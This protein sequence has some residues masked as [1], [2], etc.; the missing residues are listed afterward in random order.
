MPR[1]GRTMAG[2]VA[3]ALLAGPAA[4]ASWGLE[5]HQGIES[6]GMRNAGGELFSFVCNYGDDAHPGLLGVEFELKGKLTASTGMVAVSSTLASG[7]PGE[8]MAFEAALEDEQDV[9]GVSFY[10]FTHDEAVALIALARVARSITVSVPALGR[11]AVF[12]PTGGR[13]SWG[14]IDCKF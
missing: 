5:L 11:T 12:V 6:V 3:L 1:L 2:A 7:K 14:K 9:V 8:Q 10:S 13:A 4:A